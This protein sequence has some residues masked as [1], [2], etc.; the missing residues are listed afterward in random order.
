MPTEAE[1][2]ATLQ[3]LRDG[4]TPLLYSEVVKITWG[5]PDGVKVYCFTQIDEVRGFTGIATLVPYDINTRIIVKAGEPFIKLERG[6]EMMTTRLILEFSDIDGE[7]SRL[8]YTYGQG[9]A[10]P[11]L[12]LL[13]TG[14]ST[15]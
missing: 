2:L 12:L 11:G 4:G 3:T 7:L 15:S 10:R 5:A 6:A 9:L 1:K 14:R 13:P 8:T